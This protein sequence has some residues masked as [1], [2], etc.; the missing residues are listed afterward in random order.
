M[1]PESIFRYHRHLIRLRG[2]SM[3]S[4]LRHAL[5]TLLTV[6]LLLMMTPWLEARQA[7]PKDLD[8]LME[9][10]LMRR[11]VNQEVLKDYV[12][13]DVEQFDAIGPG[14]YTLF[15]GKQE[16]VWYVRDGIHVR[17]PVRKDGVTIGKSERK[18]YEDK[19]IKD[20]QERAKKKAAKAGNAD[21]ETST[22]DQSPP[23]PSK[24]SFMI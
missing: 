21:A 7:P 9:K 13:N 11:K 16:Y 8:M 20:E 22:A 12:L 10:V 19:W 6:T 18:E 3:Q 5:R 15:R 2:V 1:P 24:P 14:E 23:D 17:S 4:V